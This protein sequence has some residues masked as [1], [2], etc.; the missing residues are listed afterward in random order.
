MPF[1]D[2]IDVTAAAVAERGFD[3]VGLL[4]TDYTMTSDL[5]PSAWL[6]ARRSRRCVPDEAD[7]AEVQRIIYDELV[8]G[9]VADESR[10][11]LRRR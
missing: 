8:H 9:V 11:A 10:A 4:A 5:Y 1:I 2:L 3:T 7:R 6:A